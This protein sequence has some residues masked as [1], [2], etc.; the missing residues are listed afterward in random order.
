MKAMRVEWEPEERREEEA[1]YIV[2]T[3]AHVRRITIDRPDRLNA[4][5]KGLQAGLTEEFLR[6][7]EDPEI[8][9][10]ILTATGERAFCPGADLKELREGDQAEG[11]FRGPMDQPGRLVFE[12]MMETYKPVIAALN[13]VAIGGGFELALACDL[14]L[15]V[16][17]AR[18]GLPESKLGMGAI[19]ASVVLP[20]RIP[21]A[22][23]LEMMFTGEYI[24]AEEAARWGLVNRIIDPA[25]LQDEALALALSIADNA[26]VT[27]RRMKEMAVKGLDLPVHAALRLDVGPNPYESEDRK[28]GIAAF[29]EKRKPVWKGR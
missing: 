28:E 1:G 12:V 6:C 25:A 4:L 17:E 29:V 21:L 22:I 2:E 27:V 10:V 9:A 8:R 20:K 24:S 3:G 26:P 11:K 23:A 19:Y 15:A 5:S 18:F 7:N 13:G 14:R 16:P